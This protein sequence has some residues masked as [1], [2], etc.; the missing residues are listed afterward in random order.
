MNYFKS[1]FFV[2]F[3]S[4]LPFDYF[5]EYGSMSKIVRFSRIG[6]IYKLIK[7]TKMVSLVKTA[8]MRSKSSFMS[9]LMK[10]GEGLERILIMLI[11]SLILQH[12][13][14]CVW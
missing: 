8:K 7:V 12:V 10:I 1:W 11:T 13:T 5:L 2:D 3:T 9:G 6:K 14:A 4:I